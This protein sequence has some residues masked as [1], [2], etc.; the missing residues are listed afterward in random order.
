MIPLWL[1]TTGFLAATV[2]LQVI[3]HPQTLEKRSPYRDVEGKRP[4]QQCA[5]VQPTPLLC[6][7]PPA[8]PGQSPRPQTRGSGRPHYERAIFPGDENLAF[9]ADDRSHNA[10]ADSLRRGQAEQPTALR[11]LLTEFPS[12]LSE[13]FKELSEK[14][15]VV[16]DW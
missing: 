3:C 5:A 6:R 8:Q 7:A 16:A 10:S 1:R 2:Y 12:F 14:I 15:N 13:D 11:Q 4:Q 9:A